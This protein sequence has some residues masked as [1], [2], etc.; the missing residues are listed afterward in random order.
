MKAQDIENCVSYF[1]E[2]EM[3]KVHRIINSVSPVYKQQEHM[4]VQMRAL[5]KRAAAYRASLGVPDDEPA[6]DA[7]AAIAPG[8]KAKG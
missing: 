5:D 4:T 2:Q 8:T 1:R 7:P 6:A 3:Q